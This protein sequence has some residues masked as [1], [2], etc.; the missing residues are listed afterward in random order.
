MKIER[1]SPNIT[2][3]DALAKTTLEKITITLSL[4]GAQLFVTDATATPIG[5]TA[6]STDDTK[7]LMASRVAYWDKHVQTSGDWEKYIMGKKGP[8][9]DLNV[10]GRLKVDDSN[11]PDQNHMPIVIYENENL[12]WVIQGAPLFLVTVIGDPVAVQYGAEPNAPMPPNTNNLSTNIS[13][14]AKG[15]VTI[16][17]PSVPNYVFYKYRVTMLEYPWATHDPCIICGLP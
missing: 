2:L 5:K 11:N 17:P 8:K 9:G 4:D 15:T 7:T 13:V 10:P 14:S 12:E 1:L 3:S 6:L 16:G